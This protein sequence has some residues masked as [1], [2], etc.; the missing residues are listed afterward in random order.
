MIPCGRAA[1]RPV[2]PE[3]EQVRGAI[4]EAGFEPQFSGHETFPLRYAWLKKV[5]DAVTARS[6]DT[7]NRLVFSADDAISKFGVGKNMVGSMRYWAVAAGI[8]R[9]TSGTFKGPYETTPLG[10]AI[11]HDERGWDPYIED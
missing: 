1:G 8:I 5:Y 10:D 11:F 3:E 6:A 2:Q 9:D 4:F 7:N